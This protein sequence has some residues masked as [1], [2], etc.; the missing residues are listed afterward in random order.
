MHAHVEGVER[1]EAT[2][3]AGNTACAHSRKNR[4]RIKRKGNEE[5]EKSNH[6]SPPHPHHLTNPLSS[7]NE[8][9]P[10][11]GVQ[12]KQVLR[13]HS[14]PVFSQQ[15]PPNHTHMYIY[16][17]INTQTHTKA[18]TYIYVCVCVNSYTYIYTYIHTHT[19]NTNAHT[20]QTHTP[21]THTHTGEKK[22]E[23][24]HVSHSMRLGAQR[25]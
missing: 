24:Q 18:H 1:K 7:N 14:F 13:I 8:L 3:N 6:D 11:E 10:F 5:G 4:H 16:A 15:L 22:Q 25:M 9:A 2:E 17:Y 23:P 21:Y 12:W 20:T 19:H